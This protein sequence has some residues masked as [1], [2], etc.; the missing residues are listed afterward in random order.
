MVRRP[1]DSVWSSHRAD[2]ELERAA[3][4]DSEI[5]SNR[6]RAVVVYRAFVN[7]GFKQEKQDRL[8]AAIEGRFLGGEEC[9]SE[10]KHS[11]WRSAAESSHTARGGLGRGGMWGN[12]SRR[13]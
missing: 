3:W 1:E 7:A 4:G 8:Y 6:R 11:D 5:V 9:T 2:L 12:T 10:V 13:G